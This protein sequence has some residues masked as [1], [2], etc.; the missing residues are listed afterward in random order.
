MPSLITNQITT[1]PILSLFV[2]G[3]LALTCR[4]SLAQTTFPQL[5]PAVEF[6]Q[7]NQNLQPSQNAFQR[8]VVYVDS[9][10]SQILQR[11]RQIESS[12]YIRQYNGSNIIQLGVFSNLSN[13]QQRVRELQVNGINGARILQFS[14]QGQETSIIPFNSNSNDAVI[15]RNNQQFIQAKNFYVV[16]PTNINSLGFLGQEIQRKIGT[17]ANIFLRSQPLGP[18]IAIGG[19]RTRTEAEQ[20]NDYM[21]KLG[22]GNARVYYGK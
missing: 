9:D 19:F 2:A 1:V 10:N 13:A 22:Y 11:V 5:Q 4:S 3:S 8:Y 20:W 16:I 12:A 17:N 6:Y 15:L 7:N 21:R 14:N 18:H